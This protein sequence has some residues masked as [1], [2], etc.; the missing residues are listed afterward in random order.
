MVRDVSI[1]LWH[2][3]YIF[4]GPA[5]PHRFLWYNTYLVSVHLTFEL[6]PIDSLQK[7]DPTVI[8]ISPL[9]NKKNQPMEFAYYS[10]KEEVTKII[11]PTDCDWK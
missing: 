10:K 3:M 5:K 4:R 8:M 2:C 1:N 11:E 9:Y 7:Q 6:A